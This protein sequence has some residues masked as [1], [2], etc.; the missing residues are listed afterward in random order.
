MGPPTKRSFFV[1]DDSGESVEVKFAA[2]LG[3]VPKV[4]V[5]GGA[6]MDVA[7]PLPWFAWVFAFVPFLLIPLG[8][9]LG[10]MLG[11]L[12]CTIVLGLFRSDQPMGLKIAGSIGITIFSGVTYIIVG[13]ALHLIVAIATGTM[14]GG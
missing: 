1:Q 11:F 7:P 14:P 6:P 9:A 10:G 13:V 8:G 3:G 5:D 2:N 12:A 4:I